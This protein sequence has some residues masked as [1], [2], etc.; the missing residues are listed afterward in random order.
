MGHYFDGRN[1]T[2]EDSIGKAGECE[3]EM[4]YRLSTAKVSRLPLI[5][6]FL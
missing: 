3:Y 1:V 6:G 2:S 5:F 4:S